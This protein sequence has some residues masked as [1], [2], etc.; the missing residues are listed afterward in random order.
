ME[1]ESEGSIL[2]RAL[3]VF[4]H[5]SQWGMVVEETSELNA[6]INQ[7]KR[8]RASVDQVAEEVADALL[9]LEQARMMVGEARVDRIRKKKLEKLRQYVVH[10]EQNR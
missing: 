10:A 8:G 7:H 6:K 1:E 2:R 5:E 3:A 4:G 9:V